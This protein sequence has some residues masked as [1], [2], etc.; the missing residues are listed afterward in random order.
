MISIDESHSANPHNQAS[1]FNNTQLPI[2]DRNNLLSAIK[3]DKSANYIGFTAVPFKT[4]SQKII[5]MKEDMDG[6]SP[7]IMAGDY[8]FIDQDMQL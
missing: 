6:L 4:H 7:L 8:I 3:G 5:V 1:I 2:Y